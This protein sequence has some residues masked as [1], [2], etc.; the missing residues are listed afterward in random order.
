M[1]LISRFLH[2]YVIL[3]VL[4]SMPVHL[5]AQ[6][7]YLSISGKD[8]TVDTGDTIHQYDIWIRP[9]DTLGATTAVGLEVFDAALGGHGDLLFDVNTRTTFE[10][11][12]F[13][14]LYRMETQRIEQISDTGRLLQQ[15][16]VLDESRFNNR[17]VRLFDLETSE[18]TET[19]SGAGS[20]YILRVR[21]SGGNDVNTFKIRISGPDAADWQIVTFDLSFSL[22]G[23]TVTDRVFLKPLFETLE[24][25]QVDILGEEETEIYYI[26]AFG[27]TAP[28]NRPWTDWENSYRD[29]PNV[30]GFMTTGAVQYYN[31]IVIKGAEEIVPFIYDFQLLSSEEVPRPRINS[32]SGSSCEEGGLTLNFSGVGLDI[33]NA[34][35]YVDDAIY[36]G[37]RFTHRFSSYGHFPYEVAVPVTGRFYPRYLLEN[38]SIPVHRPPRITI[39]GGTDYLAPGETLTLDASETYDPE[40][41]DIELEWFVNGELR[42]RGE[43]FTFSSQTPGN[44]NITLNVTSDGPNP[45]CA[46]SEETIPIIINSQPYTEIDY[47]DVIARDLESRLRVVNDQDA[48]GDSLRFYWESPGIVGEDEGRSVIIRHPEAGIYDAF[49]TVDDQTGTDNARYTTSVTYKVN[50]EPVPQ[51]ELPEIV[52]TGQSVELDGQASSDADGDPLSYHWM[53]SDGR[54][55][56]GPVNE[57][58]FSEPGSYNV[59]LAVDDGEEVEN[60]VQEQERS[61]HVNHP[62]V[63]A[64]TAPDHVNR[65]K[66]VFS[67]DESFDNDQWIGTYSWDFGDGQSGSGED[68]THRFESPGTYLVTLTVDDGTGLANSTAST[69]HE[70]RINANPVAGIAAPELVAPGR[71]F[72]LDG[73]GSSDEDGEIISY[74]WFVNDNPAGTGVRFE[75]QLDEP[76]AHKIALKVTDDSGFDEAYDIATTLIRVNHSPSV[77]FKSEPKITEPGRATRF[78]ATDSYDPDNSALQITWIFEDDVVLEGTTVERTF[79][80][81]GRQRFTVRVDDGENLSNSVTE[82]RGTILVNHEPIIVTES[83]IRSNSRKVQLDASQSYDPHDYPLSF[84]WELPDGSERNEAAFTWTAPETGSHWLSLIVD[85]GLGLENSR[86]SMPVRVS[87]NQPPVAVADSLIMSCTGQSIIFT[88][89]PSYDPD[90][91]M[92]RTHWDFDDGNTSLQSNPNHAYDEAGTYEVRLTLDDGFS[93]EPTVSV[94]PVI[95]EGSPQAKMNF[96]EITVCTNSPVTFDGTASTDPTGQVASYNWELGN[97]SNARGAVVTHFYDEPGTY[98]IVLTVTGSGTGNCPNLSQVTAKVHV[99]EGPTAVFGLPEVVSPGT[100][101]SL[102]ASESE[103]F[104]DIQS[105]NWQV[106]NDDDGSEPIEERTGI[107]STFRPETP[108][109][110]RVR[111]ILETDSETDCNLSVHE[112]LFDVNAAPVIS[113]NAPDTLAR[114]EPFLLSADGSHDPDGFISEYTWYLN[115][116]ELGTGLTTLLPTDR[117][118]E[119]DL[120]LHIRDNSGVANNRAEME[121]TFFVNAAPEPDFSLPDVVYRGETVSLTPASSQDAGGDALQSRWEINGDQTDRPVFEAVERRYTIRLIQDDGRG[122]S[123]SVASRERTLHVTFPETPNPELP[124]VMVESHSLSA[125]D[126]GLSEPFVLL[127]EDRAISSWEPDSTG[128]NT[129]HYGWKPEGS[130][131]ERHEATVSVLE[132][133]RFL[134]SSLTLTSEWNPANP[135][136]TLTAPEINREPDRRVILSW[137]RDGEPVASGRTVRLPVEQGENRFVL[138]AQDQQVAGSETAEIPVVINVNE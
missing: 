41:Y 16:T 10:L 46:L 114:Y 2:P 57:V 27:N 121:A 93:P 22:L 37:R 124:D 135:V 78:T 56:A 40:G 137:I 136:I 59:I 50:A 1:N 44:Y 80:N 130:I 9:P 123:N 35:W 39:T 58:D 45:E 86:V 97:A 42:G 65:S 61:I 81:A 51:F 53:I 128:R 3:V 18:G 101:V 38:G 76:G 54:E 90:D 43:T 87:I 66:V 103:Y 92:F 79:E 72:T 15:Q 120:R 96:D 105:V 64:I 127:E 49:L 118:G 116:E 85:D 117:Y 115:G 95:V 104:D 91:D 138:T 112:R 47:D 108:G 68:I 134:Q 84:T 7:V 55:F 31:N 48:D 33:D 52:A 21:T 29:I 109:R 14:E 122:L 4:L 100:S 125:S 26:D 106:F 12:P 83:E 129:I 6:E 36:T 99:V 70:I 69:E 94:I 88:S 107:Q 119:H 20:G 113:W 32:F 82:E 110:Y 11:F 102:D 30:W 25:S 34:I 28:A 73:T 19:G 62:P 60:S 133:L 98:D 75:T 67:A 13:D 17:W 131:L 8:A 89:A 24:P 5:S 77:R 74:E 126:I 63:A 132:D 111:L 71:I 23:T